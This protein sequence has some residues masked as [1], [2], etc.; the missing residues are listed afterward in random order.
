MDTLRPGRSDRFQVDLVG[1]VDLLSHHLYSGPQVYLRELLQNAVDAIT[2][3]QAETPDAPARIR[4]SCF[5]EDGL[6]GLEVTDTGIGLTRWRR[7][8]CSPPSA[9]RRSGSSGWAGPSSSASSGSA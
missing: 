2:A 1:M 7:A 6:A 9:A 5:A 8:S 3:R 4:L